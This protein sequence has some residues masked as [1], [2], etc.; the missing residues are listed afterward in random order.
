[1]TELYDNALVKARKDLNAAVKEQLAA[2]TAVR[3][4][5]VRIATLQKT[6]DSLSALVG[7]TED[8]IT[9]GLGLTD[10]IRE[11]LKTDAKFGYPPAAVR[12]ALRERGFEIDGYSNPLAVIHTT[13]K[14]LQNQ[15]EVKTFDKDDKTYYQWQDAMESF[16]A[17]LDSL[18]K[19][20]EGKK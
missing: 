12:Q 18:A 11:V 20:T 8:Q 1:M 17:I 3:E 5:K 15:G 9:D 7:E 19:T 4:L 13:L 6:V 14:R 2:E 10:A 16:Q